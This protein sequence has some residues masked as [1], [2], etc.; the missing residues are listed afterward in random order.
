MKFMT[1]I[2]WTQINPNSIPIYIMKLCN[3]FFSSCLVKI[4]NL[5]FLTWIFPD[6]CKISE[7]VP[8]FKKEDPLKCIYTRMY[9]FLEK[10]NLL[11]DKQFGFRSKHSTTHALISLTESIKNDLDK[12]EIVSGIFI[13]LEKTFDNVNHSI[14]CNKLNYYGF[15]GKFKEVYICGDFNLDLLK[16][17]TDH[18]TPYFFNLL[19]SYGMLH[20][21]TTANQ[22]D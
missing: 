15:R 2:Q 5:S 6:L 19:C 14:L 8:I 20:L 12:K 4:V 3:D 22:S 7:V 1:L 16:I 11:Q 13:D 18:F 17:D 9:A 10:N 21:Y